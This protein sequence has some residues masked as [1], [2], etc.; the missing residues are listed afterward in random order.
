MKHLGLVGWKTGENSFG[1]TLPYLEFFRV[2]G[3]VD[4]IMPWSPFNPELDLLILPGGSDVNPARYEQLPGLFTTKP[5]LF[6]EHFDTN[7]LPT[8]IENGTPIFGICRGHQTLAVAFKGSLLQDMYHETSI[9]ER[10]ELVHSITIAANFVEAYDI[11]IP[12]KE[13]YKVNS[14]HHQSIDLLPECLFAIAKHPDD[15]TVEAMCHIERPIASVQYHPEEMYY[16]DPLV[17]RLIMSLLEFPEESP[18]T[19]GRT[20]IT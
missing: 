6:K 3:A 15:E 8:Y 9:K 11:D 12:K 18:Y 19:A 5:D 17:H 4:I 1:A 20:W 13:G 14:L 16:R 10:G 7:L 2:Y